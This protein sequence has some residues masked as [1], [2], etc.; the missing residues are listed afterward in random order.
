M[1]HLFDYIRSSL[2]LAL[3]HFVALWA[4]ASHVVASSSSSK[5][6]NDNKLFTNFRVCLSESHRTQ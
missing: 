6:Q 3:A 2:A 1:I 5:Q 4:I